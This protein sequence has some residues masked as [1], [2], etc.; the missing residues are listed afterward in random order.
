[1]SAYHPFFL[2]C[3]RQFLGLVHTVILILIIIILICYLF[4]Y[5]IRLGNI[6]TCIDSAPLWSAGLYRETFAVSNKTKPV[7]CNLLYVKQSR[8]VLFSA[9]CNRFFQTHHAITSFE[10]WF[11]YWTRSPILPRV[12]CVFNFFPLEVHHSQSVQKMKMWFSFFNWWMND[13]LLKGREILSISLSNTM[14]F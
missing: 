4:F 7:N 13:R 6:L 9:I 8:E 3:K 5:R 2:F 11:I 14:N 10:Y 1:M 12:W